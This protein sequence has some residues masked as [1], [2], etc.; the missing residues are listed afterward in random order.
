MTHEKGHILQEHYAIFPNYRD[1]NLRNMCG[2]DIK[3]MGEGK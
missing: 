2:M 3:D 1:R